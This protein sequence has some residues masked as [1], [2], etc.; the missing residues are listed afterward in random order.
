M[1]LHFYANKE[2][3]FKENSINDYKEIFKDYNKKK[4]YLDEALKDLY[5]VTNISESKIN[6][7]KEDIL[8]KSSEFIESN[9]DII[10]KKYP[11]L[12]K[13][14]A[15][16]IC[17]YNCIPYESHFSPYIILNTILCEENNYEKFNKVSKYFYIFL[18]A[19]RKLDRYYIGSKYLYKCIHKKVPLQ[20]FSTENAIVYKRGQKKCFYGFTSFSTFIRKNFFIKDKNIYIKS[21]TIFALY[22]DIYGY[23]ISLFNKLMEEEIILEPEQRCI[24]V[25][26][27]PS[28]NRNKFINIRLKSE[29][30]N[31][32]LPNITNE[33]IINFNYEIKE[34][35]KLTYKLSN[36]YL[37]QMNILGDKFFEKN[38]QFLS[39]IYNNVEHHMNSNKFYFDDKTFTDTI[40]IYLKGF[41][42]VS[43]LSHMFEDCK[44]LYSIEGMIITQFIVNMKQ[45]F[46]RCSSLSYIENINKWN[47]SKVTDMSYIFYECENLLS[48]PDISNWDTSNVTNINSIFI[49]CRNLLS[50]PDISLWNTSKMTNM[51]YAFHGCSS[52]KSLPDISRWDISNVIDIKFMFS[53]C[54]SLSTLPDI[55]I[56]NISKVKNIE[57]L[58]SYCSSLSRLPEISKW[59]ISLIEDLTGLFRQC[60]NLLYLPDISKW[61]ITNVK[62]ISYLFDGCSKLKKLPNISIWNASNF[63]NLDSV[64]SNCPSLLYLP[65]ISKWDLSNINSINSLFKNCSSLTFL[66]DISKWNT[67]NVK[68]MSSV[69]EGCKSLLTL[70]DISNW[71]IS[72]V[73]SMEHMFDNCGLLSSIPDISK[74]RSDYFINISYMFFR[75]SSLISI[76]DLTGIA[77]TITKNVNI[78]SNCISLSYIP[79]P[80]GRN[81]RKKELVNSINCLFN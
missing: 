45:M 56:W 36:Y 8:S 75:C 59:N 78:F 61:D 27:I 23:D 25:N 73:Y 47:T 3:I 74:W 42:K 68:K 7:I 34:T 16:I 76:P 13:G 63:I 35:I 32:I 29:K 1:S 81:I 41:D 40:I 15:Q 49:G 80:Y 60:R 6:A 51:S 5:K 70:P 19:L 12:T 71:D 48:L 26:A 55:S 18:K 77:N 9:F 11:K 10:N 58:F 17:S 44:Y 57:Y 43:D 64:F 14:E 28:N 21:G 66:P 62:N 37:Y 46:K 24:I 53:H 67:S 50:L 39:Y 54:S 33:N 31:N 4:I 79:N 2:D 38:K 52:L 65:D 20:R 69:F 22:G 30:F 72:S